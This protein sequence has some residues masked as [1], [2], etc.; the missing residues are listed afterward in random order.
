M[1]NAAGM[2]GFRAAYVKQLAERDPK[3][4]RTFLAQCVHP[5]FEEGGYD[6]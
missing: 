1:T 4:W 3:R 5:A 6:Q 2:F